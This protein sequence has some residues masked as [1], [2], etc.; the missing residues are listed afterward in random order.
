[1]YE[2]N[3]ISIDTNKIFLKCFIEYGSTVLYQK[4][5]LEPTRLNNVSEQEKIFRMAG[6]NGCIGSL[7]ATH[8][9]ILKCPQ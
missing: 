4:W 7:D 8:I 1:M 2:A 6:F 3:G 5:V 9:P